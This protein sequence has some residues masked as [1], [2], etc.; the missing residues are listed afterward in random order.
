MIDSDS[1]TPASGGPRTAPPLALD[2]ALF[3]PPF[4]GLSYLVPPGWPGE[5]FARGLRVAVPMGKSL[6]AGVVLGQ[7][8]LPQGLGFELKA[9]AWPLERSPL[10]AGPVLDLCED[11]ARRQGREP[12]QVV[13]GVL[14]ES[15]RQASQTLTGS[16]SGARVSVELSKLGACDESLL[17]GLRAGFLDGSVWLK[18]R[19]RGEE[20][21]V[22]LV[23][24]PPWGLRPGAIRQ[25]DLLESLQAGPV[26]LSLLRKRVGPALGQILA[27]L[28]TRGLVEIGVPDACAAGPGEA[29][30]SGPLPRAHVPTLTPDQQTALDGLLPLVRQATPR[31]RPAL[32][33][34]VTGSGKTRV[35]L[36]LAKA[37]LETGRGVLLLAPEAVLAEKLFAAAR[38]FFPGREVLLHHG[39]L[40]QTVRAATFDKA[41]RA[42]GPVVACGTR[43]ALFL[44]LPS[45]GL[46]CLDEEHD[47]SFKQ[48]ERTVY[49]AKELAWFLA[50]RHGAAV[51]L[52]SATPDV[53][54]WQAASQGQVPL[55]TMEH[56]AGGARLPDIDIVPAPGPKAA[57]TGSP[58]LG[59]HAALALRETLDQGGQAIILLNR[60]GFAPT[61]YCLECSTTLECGDCAVSLTYHKAAGRLRC[62][63][64]G[65]SEPFP[66]PCPTCGG[67]HYLPIGEGTQ[68][69]QDTLAEEFGLAERVGRLDRDNA[70]DAGQAQAILSRFGA[71]ELSVLVGT[72]MISKGHDFPNV[73]LVIVP[74]ADLGLAQPDFRASE[75][76][77][78]LLVQAAGRAG[79]GSAQ[80]RVVIQTRK[81]GDEFFSLVR[82]QDYPR[83]AAAELDRRRRFN[84]PPFTKLSLVRLSV[85]RDNPELAQA[86]LALRTRLFGL[87]RELGATALGPAAAPI[88]LL[89]GR[90][91][92]HVV[93]K[94]PDYLAARHFF[95]RLLGFLPRSRDIRAQLDADPMDML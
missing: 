82:E 5:V 90:L 21:V 48:D 1:D 20:P 33:R 88:A 85:P 46:V 50:A 70:R 32:L 26:P 37:A 28:Q 34:G 29:G 13:A 38:D 49:Q 72:Q 63:Y 81:P 23:S 41:A 8:P 45:L 68:S 24:G 65:K 43:S 75:R 92:F 42:C 61:L 56:R 52:G 44:P 53:K 77:F 62:H 58:I 22:R 83:F 16:V 76:V 73:K 14:P 27:V 10:L 47:A 40:S 7:G 6:R 64:C 31:P 15:L 67:C 89:R 17:A 9:V 2:V 19:R 36:E 18:A 4:R 11:L 71:G 30:A 93:V 55:F 78:S 54:T 69:L 80:G 95:S 60:R 84:Y 39:Y 74:E 79:R 59:P 66:K 86:I 35:Y 51:V 94:S 91:R 25:I 12:G 87:A 3:S 57:A